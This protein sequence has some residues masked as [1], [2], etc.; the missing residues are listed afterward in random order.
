MTDFHG[1]TRGSF[2]WSEN[3]VLKMRQS[4]LLTVI[5]DIISSS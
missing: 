1:R 2:K 4:R 3:I 5:L